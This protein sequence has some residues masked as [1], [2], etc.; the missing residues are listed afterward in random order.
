MSS[1]SNKMMTGLVGRSLLAAAILGGSTSGQ[2]YSATEIY[3]GSISWENAVLRP[4]GQLLL[5]SLAE[6]NVYGLDPN[7]TDP[8][9]TIVATLPGVDSA[10]GIANIGGD[11]YAVSGGVTGSDSTYTNET[12]WTID[13]STALSNGTVEPE[14]VLTE[15]TAQNF[16]GLIALPSDDNILLLGD[17]IL[18]LVWRIDIAAK[19]A[20]E[21]FSDDLM[22]V[23]VNTTFQPALGIDGVK[24]WTNETDGQLWLYFTNVA[25]L[26]LARLPIS[27]DATTATG[28]AELV[29]TF[30]D[31]D[32]WDDLAVAQSSGLIFGAQ[33]PNY[34]TLVDIAT[35]ESS[36]VINDTAISGGPTAVVLKGDGKTGWTFA[37]GGAVLEL[38][39]PAY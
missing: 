26:S 8:A 30:E 6:A 9:L 22:A 39:L 29:D 23:P 31:P 21:A 7:A 33:N 12:I 18:G 27:D 11:K 1:T 37:R 10:Q 34:I 20:T 28:A 3:S 15:P 35:G 24:L 14:F 16:N 5:V 19:T 36:V 13:F 17:S 38:Q 32:N 25:A 2:E 4:N